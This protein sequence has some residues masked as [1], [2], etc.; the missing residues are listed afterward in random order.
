M[1]TCPPVGCLLYRWRG[2][3]PETVDVAG[4]R[5][6]PKDFQTNNVLLEQVGIAA[7]IAG[8]SAE[9]AGRIGLF[10][11]PPFLLGAEYQ[12]VKMGCDFRLKSFNDYRV[13][14]GLKRMASWDELTGDGDVR[15][16]LKS[17]YDNDVDRLELVIGL[18][19]EQGKDGALFG[20]LMNTM[21]AS[22]AFAG[23][24][25]GEQALRRQ[26]QGCGAD[27]GAG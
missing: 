1:P 11:T 20:S 16:A 4:V 5:Y 8:A 21:V 9:K 23:G 14:I 17:V 18:L 19:A 27:G 24:D 13:C 22:D 25:H 7:L 10:N 2:L 3:V 26:A 15:N 12:S 6:G